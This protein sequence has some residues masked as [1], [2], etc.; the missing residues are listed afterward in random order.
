MKK[1]RASMPAVNRKKTVFFRYPLLPPL[2]I[3]IGLDLGTLVCF[4]AFYSFEFGKSLWLIAGLLLAVASFPFYKK[5][6]LVLLT[7][8]KRG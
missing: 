3:A 7:H 4:A 8:Q 5:V 2:L 1:T 6:L